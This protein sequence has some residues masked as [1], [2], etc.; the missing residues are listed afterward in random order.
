M[1]KRHRDELKLSILGS[2]SQKSKNDISE[3]K[4]LKHKC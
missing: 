3:I 2:G 1:L 4:G